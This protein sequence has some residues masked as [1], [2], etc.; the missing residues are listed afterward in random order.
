[1]TV[2]A[3]QLRRAGWEQVVRTAEQ[4]SWDYEVTRG[5][6]EM[7]RVEVKGSTLPIRTIEVTRKERDSA[8]TF[9]ASILVLV[10]EIELDRSGPSASG[11]NPRV[12]DR[13]TPS[14]DEF[15]AQRYTYRVP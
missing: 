14:P 4:A 5:I 13:W 10:D 7:A 2:A 1:M 3:E 15:V 11:G 8:L 9:H 12:I 6:D